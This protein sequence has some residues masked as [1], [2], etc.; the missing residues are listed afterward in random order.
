MKGKKVRLNNENSVIVSGRTYI[1]L[2]K[3]I[4]IKSKVLAEKIK[5]DSS[6]TLGHLGR[7]VEYTGPYVEVGTIRKLS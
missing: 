3:A 4:Q 2:L 5:Y 7:L 1:T 6:V